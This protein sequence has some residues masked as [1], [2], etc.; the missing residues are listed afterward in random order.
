MSLVILATKVR[1]AIRT[2]DHQ[3]VDFYDVFARPRKIAGI[4]KSP[5]VSAL[6][7]DL[8][9][10]QHVPRRAQLDRLSAARKRCTKTQAQKILPERKIRV[11][12]SDQ[13]ASS[14]FAHENVLKTLT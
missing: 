2:V 14:S 1:A 9:S 8:H 10:A 4:A 6:D 5:A 11:S 7:N 12:F 3:G 13:E